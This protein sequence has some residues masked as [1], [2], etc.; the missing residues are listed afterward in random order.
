M[1]TLA[2]QLKKANQQ[3]AQQQT[4]Q[5][6][7]DKK[8]QTLREK[9]MWANSNI[10]AAK[11]LE[12]SLNNEV[13]YTAFSKDQIKTRAKKAW[14]FFENTRHTI[15][16]KDE[17]RWIKD[18]SE[19]KHYKTLLDQ[20]D[21]DIDKTAVY[22]QMANEWVIDF[23]KFTKY[24]EEHKDD[25]KPFEK[26]NKAVED[27]KWDFNTKI[28]NA[29]SPYMEDVKDSYQLNAMTKA[30]E[31]MNNQFW[32]FVDSYA[33]TYKSTRDKKLLEDFNSILT[34]Y[35]NDIINFTKQWAWHLVNEWQWWMKA[36]Y[37]TLN[38]E[39][40]RELANDIYSIQSKAENKMAVAAIKDNFWDSW[41]AFK[42]WNL[43]SSVAELFWAAANSANW[44]LDKAGNIIEEWKQIWLG[45]YDVVEELNHL[46]VYS[47]DA[48]ALEKA[49]GTMWSW[50]SSII[51]AA[52]TI[53]PLVAD[54]LFWTKTGITGVAKWAKLSKTAQWAERIDDVVSAVFKSKK[55]YKTIAKAEDLIETS[56]EWSTLGA[57]YMKNMMDDIILF[58]IWFQQFEW[59]PLSDDDM[60][61]N[62][63]FNL[64]LDL[65]AARLA[66]NS[67]YF[68]A[69]LKETDLVTDSISDEA[70]KIYQKWLK[71][72]KAEV[73][74]AEDYYMLRSLET[75]YIP[76]KTY[77]LEEIQSLPNWEKLVQYIKK[78]QELSND[79]FKRLTEF[80]A[81]SNDILL[82]TQSALAK[83]SKWEN[84][85]E[86]LDWWLKKLA[87]AKNMTNKFK[88]QVISKSNIMYIQSLIDDGLIDNNMLKSALNKAIKSDD[89]FKELLF[90]VFSDD[91]VLY[92]R[93][94]KKIA[95]NWGNPTSQTEIA[96]RLNNTISELFQANPGIIKNWDIVAWYVRNA[97]DNF[98]NIFDINEQALTEDQF[99]SRLSRIKNEIS[100]NKIDAN[101]MAENLDNVISTMAEKWD[102]DVTQLFS[103]NWIGRFLTSQRM[104]DWK[105]T[106]D[107]FT[108]IYPRHYDA[109]SV[110]MNNLLN[111]AGLKI[112]ADWDTLR[113]MWDKQ[114][115]IKLRESFAKLKAFSNV[116]QLSE[117][118]WMAYRLMFAQEYSNM[119]T[120]TINAENARRASEWLDK[121]TVKQMQSAADDREYWTDKLV[122][123]QR[124]AKNTRW[125]TITN[126]PLEVKAWMETD[127]VDAKIANS[128]NWDWNAI[129]VEQEASKSV[130]KQI[131]FNPKVNEKWELD[132][133]SLKD[134][135][136]NL[137]KQK[138]SK[139]VQSWEGNRWY[140]SIRE[141]YIT[142]TDEDTLDAIVEKIINT[143][144][145][146][147]TNTIDEKKEV[148]KTIA[149][150][151]SSFAM[152]PQSAFI[153]KE[154]WMDFYWTLLARIT[155]RDKKASTLYINK[156]QQFI[157]WWKNSFKWW[158]DLSK[159]TD[160]L[161]EY[162]GKI[163]NL[164]SGILQIEEWINQI[165][166]AVDNKASADLIPRV[167][168]QIESKFAKLTDWLFNSEDFEW[169]IK[170]A[171]RNYKK[172]IK[173][174]LMSN[175]EL[176]LNNLTQSQI[177]DIADFLAQN[178]LIKS[179]NMSKEFY[180][181]LYNW[182][183][184]WFD[185]VKKMS[186][187]DNWFKFRLSKAW[188]FLNSMNDNVATLWV[189]DTAFILWSIKNENLAASAIVHEATHQWIYWA[190]NAVNVNIKDAVE[191]WMRKWEDE[192]LANAYF[193]GSMLWYIQSLKKK[194]AKAVKENHTLQSENSMLYN[195]SNQYTRTEIRDAIKNKYSKENFINTLIEK[196][197]N[198]DT[199]SWDLYL[200][201][202]VN[203]NDIALLDELITEYSA[204]AAIGEAGYKFANSPYINEAL[205]I[206]EKAADVY[207]RFRI[208]CLEKWSKSLN[209]WELKAKLSSA[210][211]SADL[212]LNR[213]VWDN[214]S[215]FISRQIIKR[216]WEAPSQ[217]DGIRYVKWLQ[218][219]LWTKSINSS[220]QSASEV[221]SSILDNLNEYIKL[222]KKSNWE[223]LSLQDK[224]ELRELKWYIDNMDNE[225]VIYFLDMLDWV[226]IS[227][228]A[229][230]DDFIVKP[231]D[232]SWK[233]TRSVSHTKSD[234]SQLDTD[235]KNIWKK[236][237]TA[238]TQAINSIINNMY[239]WIDK[240]K[241]SKSVP[242]LASLSS[243]A[244]DLWILNGKYLWA[245]SRYI[246]DEDALI[247]AGKLLVWEDVLKA[248]DE[249]LVNIGGEIPMDRSTFIANRI[250]ANVLDT[251]WHYNQETIDALNNQLFQWQLSTLLTDL[252][253]WYNNDNPNAFKQLYNLLNNSTA[254]TT[255]WWELVNKLFKVDADA[256][257][258]KATP[259]DLDR[260]NKAVSNY[261][262]ATLRWADDIDNYELKIA[263]ELKSLIN[264]YISITNPKK[265]EAD[266]LLNEWK[267]TIEEYERRAKNENWLW[268]VY[269]EWYAA[270]ILAWDNNKIAKLPKEEAQLKRAE[271]AKEYID[272]LEKVNWRYKLTKKSFMPQMLN[273]LN[274]IVDSWVVSLKKW[275]S[276]NAFVADFVANVDKWTF[277][278]FAKSYYEFISKFE[279]ADDKWQVDLFRKFSDY[280]C[281][282]LSKKLWKNDKVL[283][284]MKW[285]K[286]ARI[287]D[288]FYKKSFAD[289]LNNRNADDFYTVKEILDTEWIKEVEDT[290]E[291]LWQ[292]K[293]DLEDFIDDWM[294]DVKYELYWLDDAGNELDFW[295]RNADNDIVW[296]NVQSMYKLNWDAFSRD[297]VQDV[298]VKDYLDELLKPY[299]LM[300]NNN[301]L[302]EESLKSD[303]PK[304]FWINLG[305][306]YN[307]IRWVEWVNKNIDK[308]F[309]A[310]TAKLKKEWVSEWTKL[311][312]Q[313]WNNLKSF[314]A[315]NFSTGK[316]I[317][318]ANNFWVDKLLWSSINWSKVSKVTVEL[319]NG[320]A[321]TYGVWK[322][323]I[324]NTLTNMPITKL[325]YWLMP[326]LEWKPVIIKTL[327]ARW[328]L[329]LSDTLSKTNIWNSFVWQDLIDK[330]WMPYI[331]RDI[332]QVNADWYRQL[333]WLRKKW[334]E[335]ELSASDMVEISR[336]M[337]V[338]SA[339]V[340]SDAVPEL[341]YDAAS[342]QLEQ[343]T[344]Q[345]IDWTKMREL[346]KDDVELAQ[347]DDAIKTLDWIIDRLNA[348]KRWARKAAPDM[349]T[350]VP[351]TELDKIRTLE[352]NELPSYVYKGWKKQV[353]DRTVYVDDNGN[354]ISTIDNYTT[355]I[356]RN[357]ITKIYPDWTEEVTLTDWVWK[358]SGMRVKY[359]VVTNNDM[360]DASEYMLKQWITDTDISTDYRAMSSKELYTWISDTV[361]DINATAEYIRDVLTR[362]EVMYADELWNII[363][364]EWVLSRAWDD[365][366]KVNIDYDNWTYVILKNDL[367]GEEIEWT[368]KQVTVVN[369]QY[370]TTYK[371]FVFTPEWD[372]AKKLDEFALWYSQEKGWRWV[373]DTGMYWYEIDSNGRLIYDENWQPSKKWYKWKALWRREYQEV[374]AAAK[375][376]RQWQIP[377]LLDS[378]RWNTNNEYTRR[379]AEIRQRK[380]R[381]KNLPDNEAK[382]EINEASLQEQAN[383]IAE[384]F[385]NQ[386]DTYK[387]I[388]NAAKA[389]DNITSLTNYYLL[390]ND[391]YLVQMRWARGNL[392]SRN[393][394]ALQ[395]ISEDWNRVFSKMNDEDANAAIK[396]I[397][398]TLSTFRKN[399][400][401]V[402]RSAEPMWKWTPVE[403]KQ[404]VNRLAEVFDKEWWN[405]IDIL[406][407][408]NN[409]QSMDDIISKLTYS[410]ALSV[411][412]LTDWVHSITEAKQFVTDWAKQFVSE[413][414]A[415][416]V[417]KDFVWDPLWTGNAFKAMANIRSAY[418]FAKYSI[419][420]PVSGTI[421]YINSKFLWDTLFAG[422][423]KWLEWML[424]N[425]TFNKILERDDVLTFLNREK[426]IIANSSSDIMNKWIF[427]NEWLN[428]VADT[429][430]K[431]WTQANDTL[432]TI[433]NW[434][435]HSLYDKEMSWE[436]RKLAFAQALKQNHVYDWQLDELLKSLEDWSM[437]S[438]LNKSMLWN[439]ITAD[440][441]EFYARFFTNAGTQSLSRHKRSRLWW[442]NFLQWYVINR[443]DEMLQWFRQWW[444]F[445]NKAGWFKNLT[446]NDITRHLAEDNQELKSFMNNIIASAKLWYYLDKAADTDWSEADNIKAYFIDT[447]DY[448]SSLD[449]VWF[450]R[451]FRAPLEWVAAYKTYSDWS[452]E[453]ATMIWWV[454]VAVMESFAEICSQFFREGKFLS[455]MLNPVI[456]GMRTWDLDF[457][458]TVAWTEWEKM[459]NSLW[460]FGLVDWMEKYWLED[461]SEDSDII[462]QML[463]NTDRSTV[464]WKEQNDLYDITSVDKII[465]DPSYSAVTAI[466]YL[467]LVWELIKYAADK[468][469]Y[470]FNEAKYREMMEMVDNDPGLKKLYNW[471]I[472]SEV[473]SDDA[474]N[475]IWS[476]FTSFNYPYKTLKSP[477]KH[478]VWS[479]SNWVD[480]TLNT[481]KEDVFVQNIC[482]KLWMSIEEFHQ[483]IISDSAKT[484][485]K[486]KIMA[487]AEAAEPGSGKIVLSYIMANRLYELEKEYTG[488]NNPATA[489]I[490][491]DV[492]PLLK[493]E[494]LEEYWNEMFTADKTSWYKAIREYISEVNPEVF[495][496]LYNNNTLNS[497]VGSVWFM[498]M[499]MRDAARKWDVNAKYIKNVFWVM[500]KYLTNDNAR[501]KMVEHMFW[502]IDNLNAPQTVKNMA[503]EWVL[504]GNIDFYNRLKNS[505]ALS[506]LYADV[507]DS[508]EHRVWW[509][510]DNVDIQD[511]RMYRQW[512][513]KYTPYTSQYWND[514]KKVDDDLKNKVGKY[515]KPLT[516]GWKW[517]TS[518]PV[519]RR[520][521]WNIP[522]G[523]DLDWYRK[524]YEGLIKDYSDRLVKSEGKKYPAQTIEWMTFKTGSNNRWSIKWQKLSFPKHKSKEYRTNVLSNLP[525]SH[526]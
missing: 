443:T 53:W 150:W 311:E 517:I 43:I 339:V 288:R 134:E 223:K 452:W 149:E 384:D 59:R 250:V 434:W 377:D 8:P 301:L 418:R 116:K 325:M 284:V 253:Y 453:D 281:D 271:A 344:K 389:S 375:K 499:L 336:A 91:E 129:E 222:W 303:A 286:W 357:R 378:Y 117:W 251:Y 412:W 442:F 138:V 42:K 140:A 388:E 19:Y 108:D 393:R 63:L 157:D 518:T 479:F 318:I 445:V 507:L 173:R 203:D 498:D 224:N 160:R 94:L 155:L 322:D 135:I 220:V 407:M 260:F 61:L 254:E 241:I 454:K 512:Y 146:F 47:N 145:V 106:K 285:N 519:Y 296:D 485:G 441:E 381:A 390:G 324:K 523:K 46:N 428:K 450:M 524:Y 504:A 133:Q 409:R 29:L 358:P 166:N 180:K 432:K 319:W 458:A 239:N 386:F 506:V 305:I 123:K 95:E 462:G 257:L 526:W 198:I 87:V 472:D 234:N 291:E 515:Y 262:Y 56:V 167:K 392:L 32:M 317:Q 45:W 376:E 96:S 411:M 229:I 243:M 73:Q 400:K 54:L 310:T 267:I 75:S 152:T 143:V 191:S 475:R 64:P 188:D 298:I 335:W 131:M 103:E 148:F 248:Y 81:S 338:D 342:L 6:Q 274:D 455:A 213:S 52:P 82:E 287:E 137:F 249:Y 193:W 394:D 433:L 93:A 88:Q 299:K 333:L 200:G 144:D 373:E 31:R 196:Y 486:L 456:A 70:L 423:R 425:N 309:D 98:Q 304:N 480:M 214:I 417:A 430:T 102:V 341:I 124:Q 371:Q 78:T 5:Q 41:E 189:L 356:K 306:Y 212:E 277:E 245:I 272:W 312:W 33:W 362:D 276:K 227:P 99:I 151:F 439:K 171:N 122:E 295:F 247:S 62:M 154:G 346:A 119:F 192:R 273:F 97:K 380:Q 438:D 210:F 219:A 351:A 331:R 459:A 387:E 350:A 495:K 474:I 197:N 471:E 68:K 401:W 492:M 321:Y 465:N 508:F 290:A 323:W 419:L 424:A 313:L 92:K 404:I 348:I 65:V 460:R 397:K 216:W 268:D 26:Y 23:D 158:A 16:D 169:W 104:E 20:A 10:D 476:D 473:F 4:Q 493:R 497:Y 368:L 261:V 435:I 244:W 396:D 86:K 490:P 9:L 175:K 206:L 225:D 494:V 181:T 347:I 330:L 314:K 326:T 128:I 207:D 259:Q 230:I 374:E 164:K 228:K 429:L 500:W 208:L 399:N 327:D 232:W 510:M 364:G 403:Y 382:V 240:R 279:L 365:F 113:I 179:D 37:N 300:Y 141:E 153:L 211:T 413:K 126:K 332:N 328:N 256:I 509:V 147:N 22:Q 161:Y 516:T 457:A 478:S 278:K 513:N 15:T 402:F 80:W 361:F 50:V 199:T 410:D 297:M 334:L 105:T 100:F 236:E 35:S 416:Q 215:D 174:E 14:D 66:R 48:W 379:N 204:L 521:K 266:K 24:E 38:D 183:L 366:A 415:A 2:E 360:D 437:L 275:T 110:A 440:T 258:D 156:M 367:T 280:W 307:R 514:N 168:E 72:D 111:K 359:N 436:V 194:L 182:Y 125:K 383:T 406:W 233:W 289:F 218:N 114:S 395:S 76:N 431:K 491:E 60:A 369:Q 187:V 355:D 270:R 294:D 511:D 101:A 1:V 467:P 39:W 448:L 84:I 263:D 49:F 337:W 40:M 25:V 21:K 44:V 185:V 315:W 414:R 363:K 302:V 398:N 481:M 496:T 85:S 112:N 252:R 69:G 238:K 132:R 470:S 255:E 3:Q 77:T 184:K 283:W 405:N 51:D 190:R 71:A 27:I 503:M 209:A 340:N 447:N 109:K 352:I 178:E 484:T 420:S 55:S 483:A 136:K 177:K 269:E 426:D 408:L 372:T 489:D 163:W 246:W 202:I 464:W 237:W 67:R 316:P 221:K 427:V 505:P 385:A 107:W 320:V 421:M 370:W 463:L 79:T 391:P 176:D 201:N 139:N 466:G 186:K 449:T 353:L 90:A 205:D 30:I 446:W 11:T 468:W 264:N 293:Y 482:E 501:I 444:E 89:W 115:L 469:W 343:F 127:T 17:E 525:G 159:D 36:Y 74:M 226:N 308:M 329:L 520:T 242:V 18:Y 292:F 83:I 502:T 354:I 522:V 487:A 28:S 195:Y 235:I 162:N 461:F 265:K 349:E 118:D 231:D 58:D 477:G 282:A 217:W 165:R 345:K 451:L 12:D 142:M 121:L 13:N 120:S 170:I 172:W 422:K 7:Q 34:E 57:R 130:I 488:K